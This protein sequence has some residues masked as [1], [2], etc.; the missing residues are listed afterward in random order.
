MS[1]SPLIHCRDLQ[2]TYVMGDNLVYALRGVSLDINAGEYVAIM[3][4][5]GSGKSTF[6][7][8]LGALD[9]PSSG[10]L[11]IDGRH[12]GTLS[13]DE[14]ASFRNEVMGFVFQQFNLLARTTALANVEL[15]MLYSRH[16]AKHRHERA[17]TCLEL[18]GLG[19]R[20]DHH[21]SQLS[22]GQQQR[23]AI[24]RALV[25]EPRILL[26]DE[27]TGALD[28]TTS[29]EVMGIFG[30]LNHMGITVILVTHEPDIAA[31]ARRRLVFR[32]GLLVEDKS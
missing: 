25:N 7:N 23:V 10:D 20:M 14:L 21:P 31:Y 22:G 12:L 26:A 8:L 5:S 29:E 30:K 17:K 4:A 3:G 11:E 6:M 28:T 19:T 16:P 18:V 2:K 24:A 15:P 1:V 32:D 13:S 9:V 27:P